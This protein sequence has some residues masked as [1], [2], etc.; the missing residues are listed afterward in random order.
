MRTIELPRATW[1]DRLNAFTIAHEGWIASVEV[2]GPEIG[3]Q[4]EIVNL[5]LIGV[6]ADR[7]HGDQLQRRPLNRRVGQAVRR[8]VIGPC[9]CSPS[10]VM[11][12]CHEC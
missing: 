12:T 2:F 5:P 11:T 3:A 6:S 9:T 4:P 7:A 10:A 1:V 8:C